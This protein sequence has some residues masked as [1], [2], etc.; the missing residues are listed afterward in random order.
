MGCGSG[1]VTAYLAYLVRTG[2]K[3]GGCVCPAKVRAKYACWVLV[4]LHGAG[5]VGSLVHQ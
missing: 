5:D 3:R 1:I 4:C 2:M